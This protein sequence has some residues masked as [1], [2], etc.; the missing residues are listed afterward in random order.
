[1]GGGVE[2]V[3]GAQ[4]LLGPGLIRVGLAASSRLMCRDWA[5]LSIASEK[6]ALR[7]YEDKIYEMVAED[8]VNSDG[9]VIDNGPRHR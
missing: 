1:L 3:E 6:L 5:A 4:R 7:K 2:P 9:I 8:I